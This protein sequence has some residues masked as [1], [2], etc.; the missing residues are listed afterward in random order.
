M[1][2]NGTVSLIKDSYV[3][4]FTSISSWMIPSGLIKVKEY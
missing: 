4:I 2:C 3:N 1:F